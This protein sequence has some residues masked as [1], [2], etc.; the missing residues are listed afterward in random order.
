MECH[1]GGDCWASQN[2]LNRKYSWAYLK[3]WR[4]VQ[5]NLSA[6]PKKMILT[7]KNCDSLLLPGTP[8]QDPS[9]ALTSTST[10]ACG[11]RCSACGPCC[12]AS[13]PC[14]RACG[15]CCSAS[16]PCCRAC[17]PCCSARI[18]CSNYPGS[19][20]GDVAVGPGLRDVGGEGGLVRNASGR[21]TSCRGNNWA[22]SFEVEITCEVNV[23][24]GCLVGWRLE[25]QFP[26]GGEEK[27]RRMPII[28]AAS[29]EMK[30]WVKC[31]DC[32]QESYHQSMKPPFTRHHK[33]HFNTA[34]VDKIQNSTNAS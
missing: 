18:S 34:R 24:A 19:G 29:W 4:Y 6:S 8:H 30:G 9:T 5:L 22:R 15:P 2:M 32:L 7:V 17:G 11:P 21:S 33:T 31:P 26:I 25:S 28:S 3:S 20:G 16:G 10:G 27:G 1:P 13:D 14:C 12:S 23:A